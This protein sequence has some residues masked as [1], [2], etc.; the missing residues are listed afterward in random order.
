MNTPSLEQKQS[1]LE[2]LRDV[3]ASE[4]LANPTDASLKS[5]L[6]DLTSQ[7]DQVKQAIALH[8]AA[9]RGA[10]EAT[11]R[12]EAEERR[13][14][15]H[16]ARRRAIDIAKSRVPVAKDIE[17]TIAHLGKLLREWREIG[18]D[19]HNYA[20]NVCAAAGGTTDQRLDRMLLISPIAQCF[21]AAS[22]TQA[23][24]DAGIPEA[25]SPSA[26]FHSS[27]IVPAQPLSEIAVEYAEALDTK[28][29]TFTEGL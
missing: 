18:R 24:L 15:A 19:C 26:Q 6:Q 2:T 27:L 25:I 17:K 16:S 11:R 28:L 7:I 13:T 20:S 10:V 29:T 9:E 12:R 5:R 1:A 4:L 8:A 3:T 14:V 21:G 22:I 23:M